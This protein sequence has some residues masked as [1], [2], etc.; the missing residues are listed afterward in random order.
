MAH[1][2]GVRVHIA[3]AQLPCVAGARPEE[4]VR[5]GEEYELLVAAPA[6]LDPRAFVSATDLPLTRI[7][8]IEAGPPEVMTVDA[9]DRR[10]E[11]GGGYDHFSA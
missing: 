5:S 9:S 7:G 8:H 4:A 3:L 2:S 11:I 6:A 1:A 10:V